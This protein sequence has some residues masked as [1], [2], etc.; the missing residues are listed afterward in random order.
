MPLCEQ[1]GLIH[2]AARTGGAD[3]PTVHAGTRNQPL[4]RQIDVSRPLLDRRRSLAR[5]RV[6]TRAAALAE[7]AEVERDHVVAARRGRLRERA[8]RRAVPIALMQQDEAGA[9]FLRRI[10][11]GFQNRSVFCL[12]PDARGCGLRRRPHRRED[13]RECQSASKK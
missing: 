9:G 4:V 12:E 6:E 7:A 13:E 5:E 8:P 10:V 1:H 11:G 3:A 2:A